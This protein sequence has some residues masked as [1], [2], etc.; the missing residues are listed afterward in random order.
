[1]KITIEAVEAKLKKV[2]LDYEGSA[3]NPTSRS[4]LK[5]ECLAEGKLADT[6]LG[7]DASNFLW[8]KDNCIRA[9]GITHIKS[10]MELKNVTME[11]GDLKIEGVK[12]RDVKWEPIG[13]RQI[14]IN[15][16]VQVIHTGKQLLE[17]DKLQMTTRPLKLYTTQD[18]LFT[19]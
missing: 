12:V 5:F 14:V 1:M 18:D 6:L 7:V 9:L 15:L 19:D 17:F 16:Q 10:K 11:F 3:D 2:N 13:G 4:D 8:D